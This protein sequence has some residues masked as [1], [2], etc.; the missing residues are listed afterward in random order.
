M[1]PSSGHRKLSKAASIL[2]GRAIHRMNSARRGN[3]PANIANRQPISSSQSGVLDRP[4][5]RARSC[6]VGTSLPAT[7][8]TGITCDR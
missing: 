1:M 3:R 8:P 2:A 4:E 6:A 7:A 5:R